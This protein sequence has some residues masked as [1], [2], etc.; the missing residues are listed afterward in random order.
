MAIERTYQ[1]RLKTRL[2]EP[3][4]IASVAFFRFLFGALMLISVVRFWANGWIKDFYITPSFHFHYLGFSWLS[5]WPAWGMYLH[6]VVLGV[7]S[8]F[9]MLGLFYRP[10]SI[11]LFL[12]FTYVELCEKATYLN[13]YY[14]ISL[15]SLLFIV[16]PLDRAYSLDA[17][18]N[19][20]IASDTTPGWVLLILRFQIGLVY[21]FAGVA[22]LGPDWLLRAEPLGIWLA[23]HTDLPLIGPLLA[24]RW[25]A[26]A[27]SLFGAAFDLTVVFF[28]M[29]RRTRPFAYAV[30]VLFHTATG[31]LFPIGMFPWIMSGAALVFFPPDW[32]R[33]FLSRFPKPQ[34]ANATTIRED[35]ESAAKKRWI[36]GLLA[37]YASLQ[38]L[39]PL[40]HWAF[41]GNTAFSEEGFR[42]AWRVM[43]VE[44]LGFLEYRV[45]NRLTGKT[46]I[47]EPAKYLTPVQARMM[48][49]SPDMILELAHHIALDFRKRGDDVA[50]FADAYVTMNGRPSQR[51]VDPSVDLTKERDSFAH[52]TWILPLDEA[53][54]EA[55]L[56]REAAAR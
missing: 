7:S 40:R 17:W 48:P 4:D 13:H 25:V 28:L 16:L 19:P 35:Y 15:L 45:S 3:V 18:R 50:V 6:F 9:V 2:F 36:V 30:V 29:N 27:A 24:E 49:V 44:K 34:P 37:L 33:R 53:F 42:F 10:S 47:V 31:L 54:R 21:F 12:S 1:A 51:L 56:A 38:L 26:H 52:K 20:K 5:P 55:P 41:P 8:L 46:T 32:P 11:A 22:K 39:V 23:A 43:L 14:L